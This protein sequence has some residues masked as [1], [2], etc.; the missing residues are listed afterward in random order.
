MCKLNV[1]MIDKFVPG[2]DV[3]EVFNHHHH[4]AFE[5]I[6]DEIELTNYDDKY[7]YYQ[8][9]AKRCDCSSVVGMLVDYKGKFDSYIEYLNSIDKGDIVAL[10][11]IKSLL[12]EPNYDSKLSSVLAT[13]DRM[14]EKLEKFTLPLKEAEAKLSEL[15]VSA[16]PNIQD[17]IAIKKLSS[18]IV[19]LRKA[20][21]NNQDYKSQ[22]LLYN[23]FIK[24]NEL[25]ISSRN[26]TLENKQD[27]W[28]KNIDG[29]INKA[30]HE[31]HIKVN[32]EY[33][34]LK[35]IL[36]GVLKLTDEVKLFS[37]MQ[38]DDCYEYNNLE[39]VK[40]VKI[41]ELTMEDFLFLDVRQVITI[42]R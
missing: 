32:A 4:K 17:Q 25:L 11:N 15:T 14:F 29:A 21:E 42:T 22:E 35:N 20:L 1:Y 40:T 31:C 8:A 41:D 24:A 23:E 36:K 5:N 16:K 12:Q 10:Y 27:W 13:R 2:I 3:K 6:N 34:H 28:Q 39:E 33:N 26:Y 9:S 38:E 19:E 18:E 37:F 7:N 30:E